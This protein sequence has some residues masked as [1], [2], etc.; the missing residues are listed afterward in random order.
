MPPCNV[1]QVKC[2]SDYYGEVFSE[3]F[4]S[5][6]HLFYIQVALDDPVDWMEEPPA[7]LAIQAS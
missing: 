3:L 4:F 1:L 2:N 7:G 5:F 6:F